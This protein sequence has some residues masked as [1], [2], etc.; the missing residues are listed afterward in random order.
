MAKGDPSKPQP[1]ARVVA[2]A[3]DRVFA[4]QDQRDEQA[5]ALMRMKRTIKGLRRRWLKTEGRA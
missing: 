2:R 5:K 3:V 1:S 4:A